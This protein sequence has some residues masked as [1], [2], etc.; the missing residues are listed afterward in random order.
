MT[1]FTFDLNGVPVSC[2]A[3]PSARL[4]DVLRRELGRTGTKS[5]CDAGDCGACTVL[6]DGE[7][8]C[9]CL[10]PAA[11]VEGA[12][13]VTVEGL[14]E[15]TSKGALL[16][17]AFL[18]RGAAQC[19]ICTPGML[20][21]AAAL[22]EREARP[23]RESV[24]DALGGVLCRCTGYAKIIDAVLDAVLVDLDLLHER[25][26]RVDAFEVGHDLAHEAR[27]D[28]VAH[29]AARPH[30]PL[31]PPTSS[32]A[33]ATSRPTPRPATC[34]RSNARWCM[35]TRPILMAT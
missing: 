14:A 32:P 21:A 3:S 4:S 11:Q 31:R 33:T 30:H 5:G 23:S 27:R 17:Q 12:Q 8:A 29:E 28:G 7:A 18:A 25:V 9:A 1:G 6:I 22:L 35:C 16:Q 10:V 26:D 20:V 24:E 19:G 13:V 34:A 2:A 15:S